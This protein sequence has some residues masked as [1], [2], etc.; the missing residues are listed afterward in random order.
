MPQEMRKICE[1]NRPPPKTT[2]KV[3]CNS[4]LNESESNLNEPND[5][6][7]LEQRGS[8]AR[9]QRK[10]R[11]RK[12]ALATLSMSALLFAYQY[13][14]AAQATTGKACS[15]SMPQL[16]FIPDNRYSFQTKNCQ[17]PRKTQ[18][19]TPSRNFQKET[20]NSRRRFNRLI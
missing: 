18:G 6:K 10:V 15:C 19:R 16:T 1:A 7:C 4:N 9:R 20:P 17:W 14:T 11:K 5:K 2:R 3:C 13:F 8:R 12:A